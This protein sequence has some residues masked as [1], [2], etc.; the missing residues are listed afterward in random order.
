[1]KSSEQAATSNTA[2][3]KQRKLHLKQSSGAS[4][5]INTKIVDLMQAQENA[6]STQN[7]HSS[8]EPQFEA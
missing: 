7:L 5:K 8:N 1:L 3:T 2:S 6:K 4:Q